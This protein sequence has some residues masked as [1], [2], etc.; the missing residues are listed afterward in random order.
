MEGFFEPMD[1][2]LQALMRSCRQ[3]ISRNEGARYFCNNQEINLSKT[4]L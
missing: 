1:G 4:C 2:G 3:V